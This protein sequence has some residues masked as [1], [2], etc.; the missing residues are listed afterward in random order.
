D[1][2]LP[3]FVALNGSAPGAGFFG[4]EYAPHV[5]AN[6]DAPLDNIALPEGV[7]EQR[8]ARRLKALDAFGQGTA[9]R[10]DP[11]RVAEQKRFTAKALRFRSSPALKAF[12]LKEEKP[13]TLA[14]YGVPQGEGAEGGTFGKACLMARRLVEH[15]VRFVEVTLDGWDTHE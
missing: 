12:D 3:A 2:D 4:V 13:G 9:R 5:I 1:G 15:G 14:A 7:D 10:L 8:L 6:L 11:D